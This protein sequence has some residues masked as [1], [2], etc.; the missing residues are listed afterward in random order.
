YFKLYFPRKSCIN[1]LNLGLNIALGSSNTY[2][3]FTQKLDTRN[4]I[5]TGT[6]KNTIKVKTFTLDQ[7][8]EDQ[9]SPVLIKIDVEGFES[10]IING[11][12]TTLQNNDLKAIIIEL[13]GCGTKYYGFSETIVHEKLIKSGFSPYFYNPDKRLLY[14]INTYGKRNTIYIRDIDFVNKRLKTAKSVKIHDKEL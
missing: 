9:Q 8:L 3:N 10:E 14:L 7:I 5:A 11:A 12:N 1:Y 4:H 13:N 2:N 6:D